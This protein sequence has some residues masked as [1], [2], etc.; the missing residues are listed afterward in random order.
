MSTVTKLT[1]KIN[2]LID[3]VLYYIVTIIPRF[4]S[5]TGKRLDKISKIR[6]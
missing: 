6:F 4:L 3:T 5:H 2:S 1:L